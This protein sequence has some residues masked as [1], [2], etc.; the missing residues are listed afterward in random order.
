MD[1]GSESYRRYL[2]GDDG[3]IIEIV[4]DY[5]DGL[6]LYLRGFVADIHLAEELAEEAFVKIVTKK[7]RFKENSSFKTWLYAIA[8]NVA[9]D[10]LRKNKRTETVSIENTAP[11][12]DEI[13]L[14][15]NYLKEEQKITLH[16][17]LSK[18]RPI[19]RQAI[20]LTYFEGLSNKETAKI[21]GKSLHNTE[22]LIC[23]ARQSLKTELEKEGF[24]YEII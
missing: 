4:R 24:V 23:R 1:K 11:I 14:E 18:L 22:M 7:P 10:Y 12:S 19:Y 16:R 20:W 8:R 2:D 3:G 17:T 15:R 6:I 13:D 5:K 21:L 9:L